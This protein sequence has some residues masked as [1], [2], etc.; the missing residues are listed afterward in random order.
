MQ[1]SQL[2]E[3]LLNIQN[4]MNSIWK[5][6][7]GQILREEHITVAQMLTLFSIDEMQPVMGKELANRLGQTPS[8]TTQT[9]DSLPNPSLVVREQDTKDRRIIRL[10]LSTEGEQLVG[11]LKDKRKEIFYKSTEPIS[12]EELQAYLTF[13]RKSLEQLQKYLSQSQQ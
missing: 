3:E 1:R 4:Q 13:Q 8:A 7:F 11:R 9:I 5:H 10:R 12:D 2:L 6:Y